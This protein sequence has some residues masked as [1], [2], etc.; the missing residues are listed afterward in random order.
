M[1]LHSM[2]FYV[3]LLRFW[4]FHL[5]VSGLVPSDSFQL[6]ECDMITEGVGE[7][8]TKMMEFV[9]CKD[10]AKKVGIQSC[11][12]K[13]EIKANKQT[14]KQTNKQRLTASIKNNFAK[15][16]TSAKFL[17]KNMKLTESQGISMWCQGWHSLVFYGFILKQ[18]QNKTF[19]QPGNMIF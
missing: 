13:G 17:S 11:A 3:E 5:Y 9:F 10:E 15:S 12:C 19:C 2:L 7:V 1:W 6:A 16:L 14:N 4:A 8:A 18:Q